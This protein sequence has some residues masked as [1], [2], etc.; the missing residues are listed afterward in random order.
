VAKRRAIKPSKNIAARRR[1]L[2]S[3]AIVKPEDDKPLMFPLSP[4]APHVP[5]L[6]NPGKRRGYASMTALEKM[7]HDIDMVDAHL[8][9]AAPP[10][11][12]DLNSEAEDDDE[13]EE[14]EDDD[15]IEHDDDFFADTASIVSISSR[16]SSRTLS[17]GPTTRALSETR[18]RTFDRA[19]H[20]IVFGFGYAGI[21]EVV[22]TVNA[23]LTGQTTF[24]KGEA[25][26]ALRVMEEEGKIKMSGGKVYVPEAYGVLEHEE[27]VAGWVTM[28]L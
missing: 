4:I 16:A 15:W 26:A 19:F 6:R 12:I 10:S 22:K 1:A 2:K 3:S 8:H 24:R 18:V 25:L 17:P 5:A 7:R 9:S 20:S 14:E 28:G 23:W 21:D 13:E 11:P 27:V